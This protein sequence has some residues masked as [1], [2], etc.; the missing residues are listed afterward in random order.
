M[1]TLKVGDA[2]FD[3]PLELTGTIGPGNSMWQASLGRM[4]KISG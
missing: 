4:I 3:E 1:A 2:P